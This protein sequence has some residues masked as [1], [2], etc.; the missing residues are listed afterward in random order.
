VR[1]ECL[2]LIYKKLELVNRSLSNS[3]WNK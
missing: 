2:E 1:D 3:I